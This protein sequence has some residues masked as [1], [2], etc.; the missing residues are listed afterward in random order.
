LVVAD[1]TVDG[2]VDFLSADRNIFGDF[3]AQ[4]DLIAA[5]FDDSQGNVFADDDGLVAFPTD[6]SPK[7]SY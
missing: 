1:L 7:N 4:P 3:D 5:N 6:S 2:V